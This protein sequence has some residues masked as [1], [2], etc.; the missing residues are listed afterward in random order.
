MM[1]TANPTRDG[2]SMISEWKQVWGYTVDILDQIAELGRINKTERPPLDKSIYFKMFQCGAANYRVGAIPPSADEILIGNIDRTRGVKVKALFLLG[3]NEGKFPDIPKPA[4]LLNDDD[5][6]NLRASGLNVSKGSSAA[7]F[8]AQYKVYKTLTAATQS[9]YITWPAA[10]P[11]GKAAKRSHYINRIN[12]LF[13]CSDIIASA[14]NRGFEYAADAGAGDTE[15]TN[16]GGSIYADD[17]GTAGGLY[18]RDDNFALK[19]DSAEDA[20]EGLIRENR[21]CETGDTMLTPEWAAVKDWIISEKAYSGRFNS[22]L[23]SFSFRESKIRLSEAAAR[24]FA[25]RDEISVS[26][27]EHYAACPFSYLCAYII[28]AYPRKEHKIEAPDIGS[29]AHMAI[30]KAAGYISGDGAWRALGLSDSREYSGRAIDDLFADGK[31]GAFTANFRNIYQKD[32]IKE[33]AAWGILAMARH[34]KAGGYKP[35]KFEMRF[36]IAEP[37]KLRGII[38]RVD[39]AEAGEN[40]YVRVVDFK[41][42]HKMLTVNDIVNGISLQLPVYLEAALDAAAAG[43]DEGAIIPVLPGGLFYLRINQ[44]YYDSKKDGRSGLYENDAGHEDRLLDMM[45]MDGYAIGDEDVYREIYEN[46]IGNTKTSKIIGRMSVKQNGKYRA[47][48]FAPPVE[49]YGLIRRA[50]AGRIKQISSGVD[51]GVFDV[52]PYRLAGA[53]P[54]TYCLYKGACGFDI[55]D[56][57]D[58]IRLIERKND[59]D[60][61]SYLKSLPDE[62]AVTG[63][64]EA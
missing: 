16:T 64:G 55:V 1:K 32:R 20:L 28:N 2:G 62:P 36:S 60:M 30:E 19:T 58:A 24:K 13:K 31:G 33:M 15:G 44:P 10:S 42:G 61:L 49:D 22:I 21:L 57:E 38:D 53:G 11:G 43:P 12:R 48:V 56:R 17:T 3:A 45:K 14:D 35:W 47:T 46:D 23:P 9:I 59:R 7:A 41:T 29:L 34:L 54:C 26:R 40:K 5:R 25:H 51:K 6:I 50:A 18:A 52:S 27:L 39:I 4:S 8:D 63:I 37:V